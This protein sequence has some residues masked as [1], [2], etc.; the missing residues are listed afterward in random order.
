ML[1]QIQD[2]Y[3]R[4]AAEYLERK[5]N[6][7]LGEG[8]FGLGGG[9]K[10][11]PCHE[12][13]AKDLEGLLRTAAETADSEQAQAI[14]EFVWF[15]EPAPLNARDPVAWMRLAVHGLAA[16]LIPRLTPAAAAGLLPRYEAAYPRRERLPAQNKVVSALK[17]RARE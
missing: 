14:L 3:A 2:R 11:D 15:H 5:R 1:E 7:R 12:R 13:F 9:P 10:N 4:Y 17:R 16:P 6:S 8:V